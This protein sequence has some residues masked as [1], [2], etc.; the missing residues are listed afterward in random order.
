VQADEVDTGIG[1][2]F[3]FEDLRVRWTFM[4]SMVGGDTEMGFEISDEENEGDDKGRNG[5]AFQGGAFHFSPLR[6]K[7][8]Q[9]SA[10]RA[11]CVGE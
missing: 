1:P 6:L 10:K 9:T 3:A 11:V 5:K 8:A 7:M 4:G 2:V